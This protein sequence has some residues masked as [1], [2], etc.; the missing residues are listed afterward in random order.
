MKNSFNKNT[1]YFT[2]IVF[3]LVSISIGYA[4]LTTVTTVTGNITVKTNVIPLADRLKKDLSTSYLDTSDSSQT[5]IVGTNP[6]NY[7]W[8]SG[9]LWRALSIN[10]SD[11]TVKL[12]TNE[13]ISTMGSYYTTSSSSFNSSYMKAWLTNTE[14]DGFYGSLYNASTYIKTDATWDAGTST[15]YGQ[16]ATTAV[17]VT[18]PVGLLTS[19]ELKKTYQWANNDQYFF[20]MTPAS[21]TSVWVNGNVNTFGEFGS[22]QT[23]LAAQNG[24]MI[25]P[26]IVMKNTVKVYKGSGTATDPYLLYGDTASYNGTTEQLVN[27][28]SGEY[29]TFSNKTW[30]IVST[31]KTNNTIKLIMTTSSINRAYSTTASNTFSTTATANVGYYLNTTFYNTLT[32]N[33]KNKIVTSKW[34]RGPHTYGSS[35]KLEKCSTTACTA[36][37]TYVSAKIGLLRNSELMSGQVGNTVQSMWTI[38]PQ[39]STTNKIKTVGLHGSNYEYTVTSTTIS[40]DSSTLYV[41]PALNISDTAIISGRGTKQSPWNIG[42]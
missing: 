12:V 3:L 13:T 25:R 38:T 39:N 32:T 36:E 21:S 41:R 7:V 1:I 27:R 35:W 6:N 10:P 34:Y 29:V 31:D 4:T 15:T 18:S 17:N 16:K 9:K 22:I 2:I 33:A 40:Q 28:Y 14:T 20:T 24:C 11:K 26:V 42:Y 8:Y 19:Y 37:A 30:R 23:G 5:F